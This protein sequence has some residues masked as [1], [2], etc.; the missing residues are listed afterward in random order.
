M[1]PPRKASPTTVDLSTLGA[2]GLRRFS[3]RV[4]EEFLPELS[5]DRG[6]RVIAE[7]V[8]Q[9]S[10]TGASLFAV[11]MLM[12]QVDWK[13]NP[14]DD[15]PEAQEVAEFFDTILNDMSQT[16]EETLSEIMSFLAYGW[17]Y[18]EIV[19]KIRGGDGDDPT[20]RS[21]Y[22]DGRIGWRKIA[23][24]SQ[25]TLYHWE[26]DEEGGTQGMWQL[27]PPFYI[28]TM[29]PI[30]KA[31]LFRTKSRKASPEGISVLR[32][33]YRSWFFKKRIENFE[34]IGVERDLAGLPVIG[35]PP[36]ILNPQ[37]SASDASLR[38]DLKKLVTSI[39]RDEQE[40]VI[41]PRSF[42]ENGNLEFT[43]ELLS[44]GG[45]RQFDTSAIIM[46]YAAAQAMQLLADFILIG[47]EQVGSFALSSNKTKLFAV[48]LGAWLDIVAGTITEHG[49]TRL[50]Q[51][52]GL[53]PSL[54][55]TLGH[56]DVESTDLEVLGAYIKNLAGA[57]MAIFPNK[58]AER[59]LLQQ[60]NIPVPESDV[61]EE[62][63]P[64]EPH[65]GPAATPAE[66]AGETT[67]DAASLDTKGPKGTYIPA[68]A[69]PTAGTAKAGGTAMATAPGEQ[70]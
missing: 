15:T 70:R 22:S 63:D 46:R 64:S 61:D 32:T 47:H 20:R 42:D 52:N 37:A 7:M 51:L 17:A 3:N 8:S 55:P 44:S 38:E 9:D 1:A 35:V 39:K 68:G 25:D 50:M 54:R 28:P 41:F 34:A 59:Y 26:F 19:Y 53:D 18:F 5:G 13:I 11:E 49:F 45:S 10:T 2:T 23:I 27:A 48:A 60:A 12:R 36:R 56:G 30:D 58:D 14:A 6:R 33:A 40:G 67:D 69:G 4:Y 62:V 65:S 31:L 66:I 57:G 21:R 24:R 29:I 43:L 16:W